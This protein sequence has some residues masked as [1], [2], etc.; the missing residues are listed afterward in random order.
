MK[1]G[2]GLVDAADEESAEK[3]AERMKNVMAEALKSRDVEFLVVEVCLYSDGLTNDYVIPCNEYTKKMI[4][5]CFSG[6]E[7]YNGTFFLFRNG[8]N[9][10]TQMVPGITEFLSEYPHE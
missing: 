9:R 8:L 7:E 1:F 5:D 6:Y 2:I 3:M 4:E 10:K